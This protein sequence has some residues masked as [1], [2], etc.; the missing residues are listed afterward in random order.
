MRSPIRLLLWQFSKPVLL[1]SLIA[2][3]LASWLM[4]RW[5]EGFPVRLDGWV[6]A[7]FCLTA[8]LVAIVIAWVTV[9][10]H[11]ARVALARPV[12]ALRYE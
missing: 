1:A 10:S 7:P 8:G 3:P 2:W 4:L 9:G 5:L 6:L 11:T 12:N